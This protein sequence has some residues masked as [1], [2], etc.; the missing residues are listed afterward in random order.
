[1]K[2]VDNNKCFAC[3]VAN[4]HGL[5]LEFEWDGEEYFCDFYT[6]ER[7]QGYTGVMHGG[8]TATI[9]DEVMA[10]HLN[11]RGMGVVTAGMEL[12]YKKPVP[13]GVTVRCVARQDSVK[14]N[15]YVMTAVVI[16]PDGDVAVEATGKFVRLVGANDVKEEQV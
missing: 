13:T 14:R 7:Y 6:D 11:T 15:I 2:L 8:I 12:R 9:L 5:K 16:L 3:G 1:M 4:P 10:K